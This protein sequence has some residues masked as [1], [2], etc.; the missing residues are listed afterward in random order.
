MGGSP[1]T[2]TQCTFPGSGYK[3]TIWTWITTTGCSKMVTPRRIDTM[4]S[5][6]ITPPEPGLHTLVY[7][8]DLCQGADSCILPRRAEA[9]HGKLHQRI[10]RAARG[11]I[12]LTKDASGEGLPCPAP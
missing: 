9:A 1:A 6:G 4:R 3:R 11:G 7:A 2:S 12:R 5:C 10:G 8:I